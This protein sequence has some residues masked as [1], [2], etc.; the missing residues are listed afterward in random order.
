MK[1]GL[2]QQ[3]QHFSQFTDVPS[4]NR[5]IKQF[6]DHHGE[7]FSKGERLAF[8]ILTQHS[9]KVVGVCNARI[10]KLVAAGHHKHKEGPSRSTFERMLRKAKQLGILSTHHT[11]RA[12]GGFS[13]NIFV[14]QAADAPSDEHL[15]ERDGSIDN[16]CDADHDSS[17]AE[18]TSF[19]QAPKE[20]DLKNVIENVKSH[21]LDAA[22]TKWTD[23]DHTFVPSNI[24]EDFVAVVKPFFA[25]A[26]EIFKLWGKAQQA[27]RSY[28]F[29][30]PLEWHVST[31]IQAFKETVFHYKRRAIRTSFV[32]YYYGVL[33]GLFAVEKRREFYEKHPEWNWLEM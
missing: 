13:H 24:P 32:Q 26:H 4:F 28:H 20:K 15:T 1:P 33:R 9:V 25:H 11:V 3:Y 27:Y 31:V 7:A 14:F 23:L 29:N 16:R 30:M 2:I 12:K 18:K 8:T 5:T 21:D 19:F 17:T 6:L 22:Q 10:A